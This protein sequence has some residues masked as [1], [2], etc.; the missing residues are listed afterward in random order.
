MHKIFR[1]YE[2]LPEWIECSRSLVPDFIVI[3]PKEAP[4]WE[5]TGCNY[6]TVEFIFYSFLLHV[7]SKTFNVEL[8]FRSRVYAV[9]QAYSVRDFDTFS[10]S[11]KN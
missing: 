4:V 5:I 7:I 2:N 11:N 10:Q 8:Y 1:I 6:A 3:D 9:R